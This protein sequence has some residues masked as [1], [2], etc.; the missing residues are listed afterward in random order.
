MARRA[1]ARPDAD[2]AR[3]GTDGAWTEDDRPDTGQVT[4]SAPSGPCVDAPV[5]VVLD[6]R[7]AP[8]AV[9]LIRA[10]HRIDELDPGT[11]LEIWSRDRFAP[12]EIPLWAEREGHLLLGRG[13]AGWWPRRHYR[14]AVQRV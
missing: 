12:V 4:A 3:A 11:V 8:C 6:N 2:A 10:A 1:E 9:G 5:V 7:R 14:F 13:T